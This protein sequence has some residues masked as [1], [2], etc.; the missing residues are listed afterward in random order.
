MARAVV[1]VVIV[2]VLCCEDEEVV[3]RCWEME[4]VRGIAVYILHGRV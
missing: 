4:L 2:V 1:V 3:W